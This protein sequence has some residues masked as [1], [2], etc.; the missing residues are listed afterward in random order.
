MKSVRSRR[1]AKVPAHPLKDENAMST[2]INLE[3]NLIN[4]N[5]DQETVS[6][7]ENSYM[8]I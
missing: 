7:L 5:F 1:K 8:V 2:L 6:D 3:E 4:H